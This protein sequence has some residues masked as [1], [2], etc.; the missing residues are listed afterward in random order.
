SITPVISATVASRAWERRPC[1]CSMPSASAIISCATWKRSIGRSRTLGFWPKIPAVRSRCCSP[2]T[3]SGHAPER[4]R[5][6]KITPYVL[7]LPRHD[8]GRLHQTERVAPRRFGG[9][10]FR[11]VSDSGHHAFL[12]R[13]DRHVLDRDHVAPV[14]LR[15]DG[16]RV[17]IS[18]RLRCRQ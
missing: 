16:G 8:L 11:A 14:D 6:R 1:P 17:R 18:F 3:F 10:A 15:R 2:R 5:R 13:T 7:K 12:E 9:A 4:H